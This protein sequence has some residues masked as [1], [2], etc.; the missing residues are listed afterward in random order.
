MNKLE[1]NNQIISDFRNGM[2]EYSIAKK[3]GISQ[4]MVSV[5]IKASQVNADEGFSIFKKKYYRKEDEVCEHL[6]TNSGISFL[7]FTKYIKVLGGY[8]E[9]YDNKNVN[10]EFYKNWE[11]IPFRMYKTLCTMTKAER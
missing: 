6:T 5:L 3:H 9:V 10:P 7:R 2:T 1:R 4:S 8:K 11:E